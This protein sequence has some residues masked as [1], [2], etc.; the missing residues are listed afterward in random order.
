[1]RT[2]R[3]RGRWPGG[4]SPGSRTRSVRACRGLRPRRAGWT[5][6][7]TRPSVLPS[8]RGTTSAPGRV[9]SRL[10]GRPARTPVNA[11]PLA[12]RPDTHD[13]GPVRIATPSLQ[14]TF[15][16]YSLPVSRRTPSNRPRF[17]AER[18]RNQTFAPRRRRKFRLVA[19]VPEP[20]ATSPLGLALILP[21]LAL[22]GVRSSPA[23]VLGLP[24]LRR[25][26]SPHA[27]TEVLNTIAAPTFGRALLPPPCTIVSAAPAPIARLPRT[28]RHS[29]RSKG[30]LSR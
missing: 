12:S 19:Q 2:S 9:L 24:V 25:R 11:S 5:L 16:V 13:S 4:R 30:D 22:S 17:A 28:D 27:S 29:A 21:L 15:T 3:P 26:G 8:A 23:I 14:R 18:K 6:A 7:L 10:N 1:M 20:A